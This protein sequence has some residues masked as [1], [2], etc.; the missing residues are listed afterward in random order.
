M[1]RKRNVEENEMS[2]KEIE[3]QFKRV[4]TAS[5][6]K[7]AN[8]DGLTSC[9]TYMGGYHVVEGSELPE[10]HSPSGWRGYRPN[11]WRDLYEC[12]SNLHD[13]ME[14]HKCQVQ[15][16][17]DYRN[18]ESGR[19]ADTLNKLHNALVRFDPD[20][21]KDFHEKYPGVLQLV[22][23]FATIEELWKLKIG[24]KEIR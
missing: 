22:N 24:G 7:I 3:E 4:N 21:L 2:K 6:I 9:E 19:M 11:L 18:W 15:V 16:R 13:S 5:A 17:K 8:P 14:T 1:G 10:G 12:C 20:E 23:E